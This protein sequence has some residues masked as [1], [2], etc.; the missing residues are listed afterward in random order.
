M[1]LKSIYPLCLCT[2]VPYFAI[3]VM[4]FCIFEDYYPLSAQSV[5]LQNKQTQLIQL[6][7]M[8]HV[9]YTYSYCSPLGHLQLIY[10][11]K[12]AQKRQFIHQS[13][14]PTAAKCKRISS[15][16]THIYNMPVYSEYLTFFGTI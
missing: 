12:A 3:F 6:F 15:H 5:F 16:T 11:L 2:T 13:R 1:L 9:F 4:C 10:F 14:L 7:F 8:D